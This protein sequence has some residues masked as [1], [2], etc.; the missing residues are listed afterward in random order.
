VFRAKFGQT[1][2]MGLLIL[3][4]FWDLK[5]DSINGTVGKI[6]AIF[7]LTINQTMMN[8]MGTVLTF[9]DERPVFLREQANQTYGVVPY[10]FSKI[11]LEMPIIMFLPLL[12]NA[13]IYF[14]IGF[15]E[16]ASN[17]FRFYLALLCL[18]I[19]ATSFGYFLSSIFTKAEI[20]V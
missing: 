18:V 13:I 10:Y 3:S 1:I 4:I 15:Q 17:F 9:S 5:D 19:C 20:A 14:G 7:F 2:F 12:I 11:I 6:G 8:L 16:D